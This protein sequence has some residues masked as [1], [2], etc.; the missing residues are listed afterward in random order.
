MAQHFLLS[1]Y[2]TVDLSPLVSQCLD[3]QVIFRVHM[4]VSIDLAN[5][6]SEWCA[7][8]NAAGTPIASGR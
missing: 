8:S 3:D 4:K 7:C 1:A 2:P 6:Y 5:Q